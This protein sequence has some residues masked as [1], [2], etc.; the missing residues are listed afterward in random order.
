MDTLQNVVKKMN[1]NKR[2]IIF[3]GPP[4]SGKDMFGQALY[5]YK[6]SVSKDTEVFKQ[7][8]KESLIEIALSIANVNRTTW[9]VWYTQKELPRDELFGL[10]CRQF[11]IK[12]SEEAV[13]P[14]FGDTFFGEALAK[15]LLFG[16]NIITDG[17]F[18]SELEPII[19][20]VGVE[21]ILVIRM[22]REGHTFEGDSRG[23]IKDEWFKGL[24]CVDIDSIDPELTL[25][26]IL[27]E[28]NKTFTPSKDL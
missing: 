22:H 15:K 9:N 3:N 25:T 10:S 16:T 27:V 20:E 18:K 4:G 6:F 8:F 23:F 5:Q 12:V 11:L 21:N 17:G 14:C 24:K 28:V 7:S 2:V 19:K 26:R 1:E 13:K